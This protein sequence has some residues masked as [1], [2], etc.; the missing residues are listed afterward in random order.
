MGAGVGL[1]LAGDVMTGRGIDQ[2]LP[3]PGSPTLHE[4][5]VNDARRYV[6]LAER[7]NG[8]VPAPVAPSWP[9]GEVLSVADPAPVSWRVM[10]L[11]TAVTRSDDWARGKAVL[12]RMSPDNV[13]CLRVAGASV[14][15][16]ANNHLLDFGFQGL[17]ETLRVLREAGQTSCGAGLDAVQ[18]WAPATV[19]TQ[20]RRLLVWSVGHP[21]SGVPRHW[22]A[23]D[24]RPGVALLPNLR[25]ATADRLLARVAE[26]RR[27]GDLVVVSVHWGSNWGYGVPPG[28]RRFAHRLVDGGVHV[29]LG[30]SSHHPKP[31]EV[32]RG[33]LVLYGCGDLVNDYEG[34][35][36]YEAYRDDLRLLY[37]ARFD[38]ASQ[39]LVSLRMWPFRARRLRLDRASAE[40]AHW[41]AARLGES[42]RELGTTIA[43][44]TDGA[45]V[46]VLG[47]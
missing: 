39:A 19:E 36:G 34:I 15:T 16:L 25:D 9:W 33:G 42:C 4:E 41:L 14:W 32:Y 3:H 28:Q 46:V 12:Y 7:V 1:V 37:S 40:D 22:A 2:V 8:S 26:H 17:D 38:A 13:D 30:H 21:S 24:A 20:G 10:N 31:L 27:D 6:D 11:E 44:A 43:P 5:Y 35:D 18:A 47:R 23:A 29:V 45:L